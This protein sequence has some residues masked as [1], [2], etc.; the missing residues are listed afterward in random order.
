MLQIIQ[1]AKVHFSKTAIVSRGIHYS[2]Q[3]LLFSSQQLATW[4]LDGAADLAEQRVAF[5]VEPGF[6]YVK[7][8]WGIWQA[9][10]VAVPLCTSHPLP[11][12]SLV[13]TRAR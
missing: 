1:K 8:Q 11:S 6:D 7:V 9:G 5:M 13:I 12:L 4:L 2:Y 10:G 3:H